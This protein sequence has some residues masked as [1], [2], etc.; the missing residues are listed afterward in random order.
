MDPSPSLPGP[1]R[2]PISTGSAALPSA[3]APVAFVTPQDLTACEPG[4][5]SWNVYDT[6]DVSNLTIYVTSHAVSVPPTV[7]G[8]ITPVDVN[9]LITTNLDPLEHSSYDWVPVTIPQGYYKLTGTVVE[10]NDISS[11]SSDTFW[12]SNGT[13]S[14]CLISYPAATTWSNPISSPTESSV[15][16]SGA[17]SS[18]SSNSKRVAGAITGGVIGGVAL[19]AALLGLLFFLRR[20]SRQRSSSSGRF[21]GAGFTTLR[22]ASSGKGGAGKWNGLS[23]R[24]SNIGNTALGNLPI[25]AAHSNAANLHSGGLAD[26][27]QYPR[28]TDSVGGATATTIHSPIG[29]DEDVSTL[30]EEKGSSKGRSMEF[31][32]TVPPLPYNHTGGNNRRS[33]LPSSGF[34]SPPTS[35]T[36]PTSRTR[37][38]SQNRASALAKLDSVGGELKRES[39]VSSS[40]TRGYNNGGNID[41]YNVYPPSPRSAQHHHQRQSLDGRVLS[42]SFSD[43]YTSQ[44]TSPLSPTNEFIPMQRSASGNEGKSGGTVGHSR[45]AARKPVPTYDD[46]STSPS[47]T[48]NAG[49]ARQDSATAP[50]AA[51]SRAPTSTG[52][53][54]ASAAAKNSSG[55]VGNVAGGA[56]IS[57][58]DLE[59]IALTHPGLNL[60]NLNHKSSF[61]SGKPLHY[62]IPDMPPPAR[63]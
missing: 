38:T 58:E 9:M 34:P 7:R 27:K 26:L 63:D 36:S 18:S 55:S 14:S 16:I 51:S 30:A 50:S 39:S 33:S 2:L 12:V 57:R 4:T 42:A 52:F 15:P 20:S 32:E 22:G 29:S 35:P 31:I 8:S 43:A 24:D 54:S 45:R 6:V 49:V 19:V 46:T 40:S 1:S 37:S 13:D 17:L 60:P 62:L 44:P 41:N 23:S 53:Y 59:E 56:Q 28:R 3:T 11:F 5:I 47:P 10:P 21:F 25:A 61:G 48:S